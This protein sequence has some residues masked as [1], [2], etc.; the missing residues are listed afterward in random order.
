MIS[1]YFLKKKKLKFVYV[2]YRVADKK[3]RIYTTT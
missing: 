2:L 1:D 3:F